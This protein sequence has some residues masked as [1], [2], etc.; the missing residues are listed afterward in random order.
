MNIRY[1]ESTNGAKNRVTIKHSGST[2]PEIAWSG[3]YKVPLEIQSKIIN[4]RT[5]EIKPDSDGTIVNAFLHTKG[6]VIY[7]VELDTV[8]CIKDGR[9]IIKPGNGKVVLIG[10]SGIKK[11]GLVTVTPANWD[12][13]K[14]GIA[15]SN[16]RGRER[17]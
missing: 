5:H 2:F 13:D 1:L 3:Y 9:R 7:V 16:K 12:T 17:E 11:L 4:T 6:F 14:G 10:N 8:V 15:R